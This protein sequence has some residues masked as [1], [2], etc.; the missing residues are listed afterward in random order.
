MTVKAEEQDDPD[1]GTARRGRDDLQLPTEGFDNALG[2]SETLNRF[3]ACFRY[4][5]FA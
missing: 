5:E 1:F 4:R 3:P 2:R